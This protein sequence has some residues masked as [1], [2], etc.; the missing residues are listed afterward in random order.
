[1]NTMFLKTSK[2]IINRNLISYIGFSSDR[3]QIEVSIIG[4]FSLRFQGDEALMIMQSLTPCF[5]TGHSDRYEQ[6]IAQASFDATQA[7]ELKAQL[8]EN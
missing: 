4:G 3:K 1:M 8:L 2:G 6:F 5:S 7:E